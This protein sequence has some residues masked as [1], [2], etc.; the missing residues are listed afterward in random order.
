MSI[1]PNAVSVKPLPGPDVRMIPWF[2]IVTLVVLFAI[3]WA[4]RAR[5]KRFWAR[6]AEADT[7]DGL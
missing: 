7:G 5:R 2:N 3:F 6:R 1:Y 4:I